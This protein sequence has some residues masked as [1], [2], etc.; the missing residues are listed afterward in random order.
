MPTKR[1]SMFKPILPKENLGKPL[2]D[3][4]HAAEQI[5][6]SPEKDLV[7]ENNTPQEIS[8][9][10]EGN[11]AKKAKIS[12]NATTVSEKTKSP[13]KS[14]RAKENKVDKIKGVEKTKKDTVH[15]L[16]TPELNYYIKI[17]KAQLGLPN[18]SALMSLAFDELDKTLN[19][20]FGP[21]HYPDD[22]K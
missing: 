15:V 16:A 21:V 22:L 2:A 3:S 19:K 13:A 4:A 1:K 20:K 17:R 8:G 7:K 11:T 9:Q 5:I 18:A 10:N 14:T 12:N 6:S